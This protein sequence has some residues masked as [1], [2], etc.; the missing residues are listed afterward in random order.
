MESRTS[1]SVDHVAVLVQLD[2]LG[3]AHAAVDPRRV[4]V[5]AYFV[6]IGV[7]RTIQEP[8]VAG[9]L[10]HIKTGHLLHAP[11]IG[12]GLGPKRI[13]L[14][15]GRAL[16]IHGL[17]LLLRFLLGL[18]AATRNRG[19]RNEKTDSKDCGGQSA[20]LLT[21]IHGTPPSRAIQRYPITLVI[22]VIEISRIRRGSVERDPSQV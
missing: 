12:Q 19:E 21:H 17:S 5:P 7:G 6:A 15:H 18:Q 22:L 14:E 13:H 3:A 11:S 1:P 20:S 10:F 4:A 9:L 2:G 8:D 16:S